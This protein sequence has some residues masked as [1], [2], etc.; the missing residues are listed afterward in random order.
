MGKRP[1]MIVVE[2]EKEKKTESGQ[3]PPHSGFRKLV[4]GLNDS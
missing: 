2:G 1:A 4:S 3:T